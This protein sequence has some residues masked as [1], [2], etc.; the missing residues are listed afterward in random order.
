MGEAGST[1]YT[2][3]D[4]FFTRMDRY[5]KLNRNNWSGTSNLYGFDTGFDIVMKLLVDDGNSSRSHRN[6][7][8]K[9]GGFT[10]VFSGPHAT[11]YGYM[12]CINYAGTY[13]NNEEQN[14][15]DA[16][17]AD[18]DQSNESDKQ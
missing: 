10:G 7:L 18:E 8:F 13:D 17:H 3:M 6:L 15:L 2:G 12:S 5:G 11:L 4:A 14:Q 1:E 9:A 16:Q